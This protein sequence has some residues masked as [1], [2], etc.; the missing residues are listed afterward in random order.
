M[1]KSQGSGKISQMVIGKTA[2][3][4][5]GLGEGDSQIARGRKDRKKMKATD[6]NR[7]L[8]NMCGSKIKKSA[9]TVPETGNQPK[10]GAQISWNGSTGQGC[11]K[12]RS[13]LP[14]EVG[15]K[16]EK[17]MGSSKE[18]VQK[19]LGQRYDATK[20]RGSSATHRE[21]GCRTRKKDVIQMI[22]HANLR[23]TEG[24]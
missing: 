14:V 11:Y 20:R 10:N 9:D 3:N 7:G 23:Q 1:Q 18:G 16:L 22:E 19:S 24:G 17:G 21:V 13:R 4:R 5:T 6:S 8:S 12:Q 2:K 15:G